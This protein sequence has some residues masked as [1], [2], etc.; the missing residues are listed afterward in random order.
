MTHNVVVG[1]KLLI[2]LQSSHI[3][4]YALSVS[5]VHFDL[6]ASTLT[7]TFQQISQDYSNGFELLAYGAR[8]ARLAQRD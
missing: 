3:D 4:E 2:T 5:A 1:S 8:T 6:N 7:D